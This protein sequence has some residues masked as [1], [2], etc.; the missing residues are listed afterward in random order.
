M[1]RDVTDAD[2]ESFVIQRS[3]TVPVV[4]DFWAAWCAPCRFLGPVLEEAVSALGGKV[5][6]VKVDVDR[7]P[8]VSAKYGIRSIPAVKAFRNGAIVAEFEGARDAAFLKEWLN[9]VSPSLA[10]IT[11]EEALKDVASG[12]AEKALLTLSSLKADAEV[13]PS[14]TLLWA[15]LQLEK[16]VAEGVGE[17]LDSISPRS[18]EYHQVEGLKRR[19]GFIL[20]ATAFGGEERAREVLSQQPD[21]LEARYALACALAASNQLQPALDAFLDV[22]TQSRKFK[23]DAARLALLALFEMLGAENALT[24]EYRRKLMMVL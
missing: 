12:N 4:V 7:S 9:Q 3:S 1:S 19:L 23:D 5:E 13:G 24:R 17:A 2:F 14:A 22:V 10:R 18:V 16:G 8:V 11:L 20:E 21:N 15:R 6:M